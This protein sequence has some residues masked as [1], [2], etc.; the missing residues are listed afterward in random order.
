VHFIGFTNPISGN[1]REIAID[2]KRIAGYG[3][4]GEV[5][6]GSAPR[7]WPDVPDP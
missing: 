7:S 1:L 6:T 4:G 3:R 5:G 2:A